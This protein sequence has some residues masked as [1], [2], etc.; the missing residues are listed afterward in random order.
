MSG[1]GGRELVAAGV[2]AAADRVVEDVDAAGVLDDPRLEVAD[3]SAQRR[4]GVVAAVN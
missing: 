4:L 1:D 2:L 3:L